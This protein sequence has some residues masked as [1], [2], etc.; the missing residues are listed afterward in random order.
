MKPIYIILFLLGVIMLAIGI[1]YWGHQKRSLCSCN[2]SG[3]CFGCK[4]RRKSLFGFISS[5]D[6]TEQ[7]RLSNLQI[8]GIDP[9][10]S[11]E[12]IVSDFGSPTRSDHDTMQSVN[13]N[14]RILANQVYE[15]TNKYHATLTY[16]I[17]DKSENMIGEGNYDVEN[18]LSICQLNLF[19]P[20]QYSP[21]YA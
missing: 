21:Q 1:S 11:K 10:T 18:G 7:N 3:N 15:M 6:K 2:G 20:L 16:R 8:V 14:M 12:Y 4:N 5:N 13:I 17:Y 19:Q 9:D